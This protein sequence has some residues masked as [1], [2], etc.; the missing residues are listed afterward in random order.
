VQQAD[1]LGQ[2]AGGLR[3][4]AKALL[5]IGGPREVDRAFY[6]RLGSDPGGREQQA[7]VLTLTLNRPEALN[8]FTIEMKEALLAALKGEL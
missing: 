5:E 6:G 1:G 3:R 2:Q 8:S 7:G 4:V